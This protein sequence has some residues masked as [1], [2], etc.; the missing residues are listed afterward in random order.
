MAD[1]VL[2]RLTVNTDPAP[3]PEARAYYLDD[4]NVV[5][6]LGQAVVDRLANLPPGVAA[7]LAIE[8]WTVEN[9]PT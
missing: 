9:P 1:V 7:N 2:L 3:P 5:A 6:V 4:P 8:K